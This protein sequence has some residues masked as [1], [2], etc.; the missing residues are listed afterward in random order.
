MEMNKSSL[1]QRLSQ[2]VTLKIF[3]ILF[4]ILLLMIPL[5]SIRGLIYERSNLKKQIESEV[6]N[7]YGRA[8]TIIPPVIKLPYTKS[9]KDSEGKFYDIEGLVTITPD[10]LN[11]DGQLETDKRKRSIYE[12]IVY[13]SQFLIEGNFTIPD[14]D[15]Q[16]DNLTY[17]F[18]SAY[19]VMG[20]SDNNGLYEDC[21]IKMN[22]QSFDLSPGIV[23][24]PL[25]NNS[26]ATRTFD[27]TQTGDL[28]FSLQ[29]GIKGTRSINFAP[30]AKDAEINLKSKWPS[31][32]FVGSHLPQ[33]HDVTRDGFA[34]KWKSN[35]YNRLFP[36]YW[37][38]GGYNFKNITNAFGVN[39]IEP[40][41]GYGK[42]T[43]TSK[44]ALLIISLTFGVF[45]FFEII[46][47][48][49]IHPIQYIMVGFSLV[50][51]YLLL[52]S[53]T[54]HLG[55]NM[56]YLISALAT[57]LLIIIYTRFIIPSSKA[58]TILFSLL[59]ALF[60]Y[61]FIILQ[62]EEYALLAGS[63]GLFFIL[64]AVMYLS[65]NI[66]WYNLKRA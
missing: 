34:A 2:S 11:I 60:A 20:I 55:F 62:L 15:V 52:I 44:Y 3:L 59:S 17:D 9:V 36:H 24:D 19:I 63:V 58:I 45:F 14:I 8:Q 46:Y 48:R 41:D 38:D 30:V 21:I 64:S 16:G 50:T 6:A 7:S 54:E 33:S 29:M 35:Q 47:K 27:L 10:Y 61:I 28:N 43:R 13:Q 49:N 37:Y 66:D 22:G 51:F 12:V 40:V 1:T 5:M 39:L 57:V 42:N 32:S 4:L 31:P 53:F 56:A 26:L 18:S 23:Q 65:R 25:L